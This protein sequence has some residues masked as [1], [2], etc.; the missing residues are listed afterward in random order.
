MNLT[1]EKVI[2]RSRRYYSEDLDVSCWSNVEKCLEK[3]AAYNINSA[4][5]LINFLEQF[6]E[7][8]MLISEEQGKR[9]TKMTCNTDN[10]KYSQSFNDYF[11]NVVTRAKPYHNKMDRKFHDSIYRKNLPADKYQHLQNIIANRINVYREENVKLAAEEQELSNKYSKIISQMTVSYDGKE[12]TIARLNKYLQHQDRKIREEAWKL[13][14]N[15]LAEDKQEL[16]NI[17][18]ELMAIR[19]QQAENAGFDNYRDYKHKEMGR[20]SYSTEDVLEFHK[21]VENAVLPFLKEVTARRKKELAI[22]SVRPFDTAVETDG[23]T[24]KP[25]E[26]V[27]ELLDKAIKILYNVDPKYGI[28]LNKM[29]NT[30]LLDLE[31]RKGKSPGGYNYPLRELGSS[32]IMMNAVGV[33]R[34]IVTLLHEA[35]HAM[36]SFATR[37]MHLMDY[38]EC[39][40]ESAELA[41][42]AMEMLTMEYWSEYYPQKKDHKKAQK[43]QL[44]KTLQ[45]LPWCMTVDAFQQWIYTNPNHSAKQ[46]SE[47]FAYL[48]NRFNS[49][50][51]WSGL[52][53]QKQY[54]W[55]LQLHVFKY[56]FYY[57]E[58]GIAQLAAL[59]IYKNYCE[60]GNSAVKDYDLLM[61]KGYSEPLDRLYQTAGIRFDFS[62][63]YIEELVK[64]VA[65]TEN[66]I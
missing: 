26:S 56:P 28:N 29:K 7:L 13:R 51:D 11:N 38:K 1:Q 12:Q 55:M 30:G 15:R 46:R 23:K 35:G 22:D 64:F 6:S 49:G 34:D 14:L 39:P 9:Y 31:N 45:F 40:H 41:S 20:F 33:H 36:H 4:D 47:Y 3:L 62:E 25:F 65:D 53:E 43:Q 8:Q 61:K 18:D 27:E 10:E 58:Y 60:K 54:S 5:D 57:I 52:E 50:V 59:A 37:D 32:F 63:G 48:V 19:R 66:K 42:M 2:K 21:S 17:F 16:D 44:I 24:L